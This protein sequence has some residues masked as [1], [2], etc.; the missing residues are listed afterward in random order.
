[1]PEEFLIMSTLRSV[2][3]AKELLLVATQRALK[4]GKSA[5]SYED[6]QASALTAEKLQIIWEEQKKGEKLFLPQ[7]ESVDFLRTELGLAPLEKT[8]RQRGSSRA[9]PGTRLPHR[10]PLSYGAK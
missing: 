4:A 5:V 2:G 7:Q 9:L 10:T 6:M 3:L 8:P 1:V